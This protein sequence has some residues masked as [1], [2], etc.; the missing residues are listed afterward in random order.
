MI[1]QVYIPA[2]FPFLSH[3]NATIL[4][5]HEARREMQCSELH[6]PTKQQLLTSRVESL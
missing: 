3:E 5:N 2:I 1:I 4:R 6:E